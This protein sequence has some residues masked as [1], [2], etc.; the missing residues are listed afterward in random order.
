LLLFRTAED[1]QPVVGRF[2]SFS[3]ERAPFCAAV[4]SFCACCLERGRLGASCVQSAEGRDEIIQSL[5]GVGGF[6]YEQRLTAFDRIAWFTNSL[7][8]RPA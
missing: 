2:Q 1:S 5:H 4:K 6:D 8:T 7:V 3:A